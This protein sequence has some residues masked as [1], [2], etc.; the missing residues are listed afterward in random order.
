MKL[1]LTFLEPTLPLP[2]GFVIHFVKASF[3]PTDH[4]LVNIVSIPVAADRLA[5][6]PLQGGSCPGPDVGRDPQETIGSNICLLLRNLKI[7]NDT[8]Y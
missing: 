8:F 2:Q 7:K 1:L 3:S 4:A 5:G 6:Q